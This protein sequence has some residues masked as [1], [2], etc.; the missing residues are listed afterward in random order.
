MAIDIDALLKKDA[1]KK[2]PPERVRAFQKLAED[3]EGKSMPESMMLISRFQKSMP[4]G[5]TL[6]REEQAAMIEAMLEDLEPEEREKFRMFLN[7]L[8]NILK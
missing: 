6:S 1:F 4:Q 5:Q 3:L 7:Q 2:L 8:P